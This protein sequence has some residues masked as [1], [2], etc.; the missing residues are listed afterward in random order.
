MQ[1]IGRAV[2]EAFLAGGPQRPPLESLE[3]EGKSVNSSEPKPRVLVVDD[4]PLIADTIAEILNQSGFAA[5]PAYDGKDAL[6]KADL[7]S[8][9]ILLTDVLMP[10]LNG[11]ELAIAVMSSH[12]KTRVLLFSGQAATGGVIQEALARGFE[13]EVLPKPIPPDQ[14]ISK[15]RKP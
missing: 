1:L 7:C 3:P 15:L 6:S 9:D 2:P 8:P 12:P 4:E 11:V 13:F 10:K 14:L 5:E